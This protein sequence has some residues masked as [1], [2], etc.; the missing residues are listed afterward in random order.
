MLIAGS[1]DP[2]YPNAPFMSL[3]DIILGNGIGKGRRKLMPYL[4]K[5]SSITF[6]DGL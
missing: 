6:K 4:N 3:V 2:G 5:K 1:V